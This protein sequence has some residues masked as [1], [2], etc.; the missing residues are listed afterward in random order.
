M[1]PIKPARLAAC[2]LLASSTFALSPVLAEDPA[3]E[4]APAESA[5]LLDRY[6]QLR[7]S[8]PDAAYQL[9]L[10]GW[11]GEGGDIRVPLELGYYQLRRE[12][13]RAALP[14][15]EAA[16]KI[17]PT[18]KDVLDQLGYIHVALE[19]DEGAL[20]A[21]DRSLAVDPSDETIRLQ[22]AYVLQR[23]GQNGA[24]ASEFRALASS[25]DAEIAD[26]SC[27][28]YRVV[29]KA[30]DKALDDPWFAE[31]YLAPQY[32]SHFDLAVVPFQGRVGAVL[33]EDTALE[34][35]VGARVT[36]DTRSGRGL[37]GPQNYYDN[38]AVFAAGLRAQPVKSV[39]VTF[40][41]EAGQAY[42]LTDQGR[43][44]WRGDVRGG[45]VFF[46]EWNMAPPC[47][48]GDGGVRFVADAYGE[49]IYYSRYDDNVL[50]YARLRPGVRLY[51][52]EGAAIDA[53]ALGAVGFDT[54]GAV[55]NDYQELGGGVAAHI[56]G[57][58]GLTLRAEGVR[59]FRGDG[60]D[61]YSTLRFGIEHSI[62]F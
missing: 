43:S 18:R 13:Y 40:F 3:A 12:D 52:S 45:A 4:E 55:G 39:P 46:K 26:P 47:R 62:R 7:E 1:K 38:S 41:I 9:L 11:S 36:V 17:D 19:Q 60:L 28:S 14:F 61:S 37:F 24:A 58:G 49:A 30:A 59:V 32:V 51:E 48:D 23:L 42:D 31:T 5:P 8:D 15:F 16:S 33:D 25:S 10:A 2:L 21:F 34:A 27:A 57:A 35:Y 56:F 53:Y 50:F 22:R 54:K 6:Y 44:R 29:Y 20:A